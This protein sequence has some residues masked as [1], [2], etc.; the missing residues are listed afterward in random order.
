MTERGLEAIDQTVQQTHV[1][2]NEISER[3]HGSKHQSLQIL[4]S[5]LH[6][7]RDHLA[8]DES[9]QFA[10]QLPLLVRGMYYEGWDPSQQLQH[11]RSAEEFIDRFLAGTTL[12]PMDA[13]DALQAVA[14]V[15]QTHVSPGEVDDVYQSLPKHIRE[16]L[17][18]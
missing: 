14:R 16:L 11:E 3:F 4:R 6:M 9:A 8:V 12:R 18:W 5:F 13:R 7:I 17:E 15:V 10:A 1:W 2:L